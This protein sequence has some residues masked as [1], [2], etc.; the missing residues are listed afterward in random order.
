MIYTD[1]L[2]AFERIA[3]YGI[4]IRPPKA[5]QGWAR[6]RMFQT[7]SEFG[8]RYPGTAEGADRPDFMRPDLWD[9]YVERGLVYCQL[10]P[11]R[12]KRFWAKGGYIGEV[13]AFTGCPHDAELLSPYEDTPGFAGDAFKAIKR[14]IRLS[15]IAGAWLDS[16]RNGRLYY[17]SLYPMAQS[18]GRCSPKPSDGFL[19]GMGREVTKALLNPGEGMCVSILDFKAQGMCIMAGLSQDPTMAKIAMARKDPY[20]AL[21]RIF[22]AIPA[23]DYA[24]MDV[25]QLKAKYGDVRERMK[26]MMIAYQYGAGALRLESIGGEGAKEALDFLFPRY[27]KW[28]EGVGTEYTLPDGFTARSS[29]GLVAHVQGTDAYIL[30]RIV[31]EIASPPIIATNHD[32]IWV[33]H[34]SGYDPSPIAREMESIADDTLGCPGLFRVDIET[35][36]AGTGRN[37]T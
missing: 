35:V 22:G 27:V 4:P 5:V 14:R 12:M 21:G 7:L 17:R 15:G 10:S 25:P 32:C 18:T 34:P 11:E 16:Y 30:R 31:C 36:E 6:R 20:L 8:A 24:S 33:E 9:F 3:S 26:K 2:P 23:A 28:K 37:M 29:S 13:P 19:P 1:C